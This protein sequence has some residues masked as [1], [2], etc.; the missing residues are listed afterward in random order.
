MFGTVIRHG[1]N[2]KTVT[3]RVSTKHWNYKYKIY[4]YTHKN[5]QVHDEYNYCVSGDKVIIRNCQK[6][7]KTKAFYIQKI[8]KPFPRVDYQ[9]KDGGRNYDGKINSSDV[10]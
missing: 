3:V 6:L 8:V 7:A 5:K 4:Q 9:I 2:N 10:I 1:I